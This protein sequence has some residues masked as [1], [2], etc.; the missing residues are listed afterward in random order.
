MHWQYSPYTLPLFLAGA[1]AVG[2]GLYIRWRHS[3]KPGALP[4]VILQ[5][6]AAIWSVCSALELAS[7]EEP[8]KL[9]WIR[10]QY[11][12]IVFIPA[13]WLV[14]VLH[15][16]DS[17]RWQWRRYLPL[18]GV[19]PVLMHLVLW[20]DLLHGLMYR[21]SSMSTW[22]GVQVLT[23][24]Y[25]PWFWIHVTYSYLLLLAGTFLLL[26]A[27]WRS[28]HLYR[29]Q[30]VSVL[31][32]AVSPWLA[33]AL[34]IF[35]ISPFPHLDLTPFGFIFMG[36]AVA[37]GLFRFRLLDVVPV[38]R[39]AVVERLN[40]GVLVLGPHGLIVDANPAAQQ[41]FERSAD[42]LVGQPVEQA[43][44][45]LPELASLLADR[46]NSHT[47]VVIDQGET[48]RICD[49][50]LLPLPGRR[51]SLSGHIL[52]L[53][54]ITRR[55]QTE[56]TL[57]R[58]QRLS[59]AGELSLGISHNLNNLLTG[60][61]G[62]A[63]L[64]QREGM[65]DSE[66]DQWLETIL[67]SA[68]RARDLVRRLGRTVR[69]EEDEELEPV[70]LTPAVEEAVRGAR[71]RWQNEARERDTRIELRT[72]LGEVP[73]L[74][75]GPAGL[76][77]VLL[78]LLF[79]AADAMPDGGTITIRTRRVPEGV[80]LS[81]S[82]TGIGMNEATRR[83]IFE[84]FFTTKTDV[85]TGLGLS[86]AYATVARWGGTIEVDSAPGR[87]TTFALRLPVWT[88]P[89]PE[90]ES[91]PEPQKDQTAAAKPAR[92]LL[93]EDEAITSLVLVDS[94]RQD[95]HR[96][97]AF[98][99]G[100]EILRDF[101]PGQYDL[102]VVDLGIPGLPGDRLAQRLKEQDPGL[103]AGLL[104]G[105]HLREDDPRRAPFAFYLQKPIDPRRLQRAVRQTLEQRA[106]SGTA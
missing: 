96:V 48:R 49:M 34:Y 10:L 76:H 24:E 6:A 39:H 40:D 14:F 77:D 60:I 5:F 105:W 9:L 64:L 44:A 83:R 27:V 65:D 104:T 2:Q 86:T 46:E 93:V 41:L 94:L 89:V 37:W 84:P 32:G 97:D 100:E 90:A 68:R 51:E 21:G 20:T 66:A 25:G 61:L 54:D 12:G 3:D 78:N 99:S 45:H 106:G 67:T 30:F 85:G 70:Q 15:Y 80:E 55:K 23:M 82:D 13:S 81:V 79:N 62:P 7:V 102:L 57:I 18:L 47:E 33:N 63:R 42:S 19:M 53:H 75:C 72:E 8:A 16:T 1:V 50:H 38:A 59:A 69:E 26:P 11:V 17:P 71:P 95:G 73:P 43:L 58:A 88:A 56:E 101:Q 35:R 29:S 22:Q 74:A 92:I 31:F 103:L 36:V 28:P 98:L 52:V 91:P 87:G 4:L